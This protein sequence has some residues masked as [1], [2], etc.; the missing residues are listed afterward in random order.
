[1]NAGSSRG[2]LVTGAS[3]G[4]GAASARAFA[5]RGERVAVHFS[6]SEDRAREVLASLDGD[7]HV[8]A[9]ADLRDAEATRA[10]V[11]EAV[12]RL[13]GLDVLVN[14]AG[15]FEA[16]PITDTTYEEWQR[17]WADTLG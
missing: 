3:R 16:H 1:M 11:S 5:A 13:G 9:G 17:A 6:A 2:V 4:I 14:N 15:I 10:M 7:G 8:L 12:A